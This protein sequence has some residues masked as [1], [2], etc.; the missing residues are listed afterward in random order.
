MSNRFSLC[1]AAG[2]VLFS[3][4]PLPAF[5]R[6]DLADWGVSDLSGAI[7]L[8]AVEEH[9]SM[10]TVSLKNRSS[11]VITAVA[12]SFRENVHHYQDWMNAEPSGLA[13]GQTFDVTVG[14]DDGASRKLIISAVLF[15]DGS[16]TGNPDQI[17]RM[18]FHRFGHILE[19]A[20]VRDILRNRNSSH[21]D[22]SM[23][24]LA[25]KIGKMP[26]SI[27][28]AFLSL[29]GVSVPGIPLDQLKQKSEKMR[30]ALFEGVSTA[31]ER[32]LR[33]IEN[34]KQLP[35]LSADERVPARKAV[36]SVLFEQYDAQST[37][38]SALIA[39]I[40]GGR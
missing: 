29:A 13:P 25:Q 4:N 33:Q 20:R 39:R 35:V 12:L 11:G 10:V 34:V 23:D 18:N 37:K 8:N 9:N 22:A 17:D 21:D 38:A 16:G 40:Q 15:D 5:A 6:S 7:E 3:L 32:A 26:L 31:R 2:L 19:G 30:N 27:E 36:L 28:D 14:P 24:A 1:V